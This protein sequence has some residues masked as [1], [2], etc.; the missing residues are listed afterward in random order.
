MKGLYLVYLSFS[1]YESIATSQ[2]LS[3]R[4]L[5]ARDYEID[6]FERRFLDTVRWEHANHT[7]KLVGYKKIIMP[8]DQLEEI[9]SHVAG[10]LAEWEQFPGTYCDP[11][12]RTLR[13]YFPVEN[14]L[15]YQGDELLEASHLGEYPQHDRLYGDCHVVGRYQ[16]AQIHGTAG[17]RIEG[18]IV[19]LAQSTAPVR[20]YG[21]SGNV[22][23]YDFGW[24]E[25]PHG[26]G[27]R[28]EDG[29]DGGSCRENHG[30]KTCSEVYHINNGR[31]PRDYSSCIDYNGYLP[32]CEGKGGYKAFVGSDCWSSVLKGHCWSEVGP[33]L[34]GSIL[35][36][37]T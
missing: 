11:Y 31:C 34:L 17:N 27:K 28:E 13:L 6:Q 22:L 10:S 33:A 3:R 24:R 26:H 7:V 4:A 1:L 2:T 12:E 15:I 19:Y 21:E 35:G 36:S 5:I 8:D 25:G 23:M 20:V 14:A 16:T 9:E 32:N 37:E 18:G 29:H 30:R